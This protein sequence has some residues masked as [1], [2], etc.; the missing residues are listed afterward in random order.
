MERFL[1][2]E[3]LA[4]RW[5]TT[6]K[7]I[8]SLRYR[9]DAP[10]AIKVGRELRWRLADVEAWESARR[11]TAVALSGRPSK[12]PAVI[13]QLAGLLRPDAKRPPESSLPAVASSSTSLTTTTTPT[14][15]CRHG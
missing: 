7:V 3:S 9:R 15:G 12:M 10:P 11:A 4:E 8:Y 14:K 6:P 13:E 5:S 2:V 1:G